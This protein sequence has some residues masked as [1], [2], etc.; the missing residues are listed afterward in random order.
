MMCMAGLAAADLQLAMAHATIAASP[1]VLASLHR[2]ARG[3]LP[4]LAA[5]AAAF[6]ALASQRR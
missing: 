6:N 1:H 5:A 2:L 4:R 3:V